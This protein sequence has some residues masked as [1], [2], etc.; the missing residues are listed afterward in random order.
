MDTA[1]AADFPGLPR[2][3][4]TSPC[5]VPHPGIEP[6]SPGLQADPLPS[7]PPGKPNHLL[8]VIKDFAYPTLV[9]VWAESGL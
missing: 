9:T 7:E 4:V 3:S 1:R 2:M 6:G 8:L 5:T